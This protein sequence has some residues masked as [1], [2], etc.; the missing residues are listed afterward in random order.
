[1]Q[2]L[3]LPSSAGYTSLP[4][5]SSMPLSCKNC[6]LHKDQVGLSYSMSSV[7]RWP[8][9]MSSFC[10]I[11]K[12]DGFKEGR[13]FLGFLNFTERSRCFWR[14]C[15]AQSAGI[16]VEHFL[17]KWA[18]FGT[19]GTLHQCFWCAG[20][21]QYNV[22]ETGVFQTRGQDRRCFNFLQ[23]ESFLSDN[24]P[25]LTKSDNSSSVLSESLLSAT[26]GELLA[27]FVH[28]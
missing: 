20:P 28:A 11:L 19:T 17:F 1:M 14:H 24:N 2:A 3:S 16:L 7:I 9:N 27:D 25:T 10:S 18:E 26:L 15:V 5:P 21:N 4:F 8:A 13:N 22:E 23:L 6:K 12:Y